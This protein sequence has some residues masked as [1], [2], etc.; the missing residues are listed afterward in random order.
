MAKPHD[1]RQ[2][3]PRGYLEASESCRYCGEQKTDIS[4]PAICEARTAKNGQNKWA[5]PTATAQNYAATPQPQTYTDFQVQ[6]LINGIKWA[7]GFFAVVCLAVWVAS[8]TIGHTHQQQNIF[9]AKIGECHHS[10][11]MSPLD[12]PVSPFGHEHST[13][14]NCD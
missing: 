11:P 3:N 10:H 4:D 5:D 7:A 9:G 6:K 14:E 12:V 13:A 8:C 1:F 2:Q